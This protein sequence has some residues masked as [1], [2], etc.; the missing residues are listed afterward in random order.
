MHLSDTDCT[1]CTAMVG[2]SVADTVGAVLGTP[3]GIGVGDAL[4]ESVT[5]LRVGRTYSLF[6]PCIKYPAT[7]D[8]VT[9]ALVGLRVVGA[10]VSAVVGAPDHVVGLKL[11]PVL[12]TSGGVYDPMPCS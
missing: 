6:F 5:G 3:V 9:G 7:G 11:G 10:K 12:T 8:V 1:F 2:A 4:G